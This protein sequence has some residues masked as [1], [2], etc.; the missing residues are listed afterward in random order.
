MSE[1]ASK[2]NPYSMWQVAYRNDLGG[3]TRLL[4][5]GVDPTVDEERDMVR[6]K[7]SRCN[8]WT[9]GRVSLWRVCLMRC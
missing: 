8:G 5:Q 2:W 7:I 1:Y 3:I 6:L 4:D 9:G